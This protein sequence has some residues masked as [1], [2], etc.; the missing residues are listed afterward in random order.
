MNRPIQRTH[1]NHWTACLRELVALAMGIFLTC[2]CSQLP[3]DPDPSPTPTGAT[4]YIS[5]TGNDGLDGTT[6]ESAW[7]NWPH[8]LSQLEAGDTLIACDGTW[9]NDSEARA[10]DPQPV[11]V[12]A[13][14][15]YIHG[16]LVDPSEGLPSPSGM[17][18]KPITVRALNER[19]AFLRSNGSAAA[20]YA[21]DV[22]HWRFEGLRGESDDMD[23]S[24]TGMSVFHLAQCSRIELRR[25]L[26]AR[27]NRYKNTHIFALNHCTDCRVVEN[28]AYDFHR[29]G[30]SAQTCVGLEFTRNYA[31]SRGRADLPDDVGYN[32]H[33]NDFGDEG[34]TCYFSRGCLVQN[35][36]VE[37]S[38]GIQATGDANRVLGSITI[39]GHFG[40]RFAAN[41]QDSGS[42]LCSFSET[43]PDN[44]RYPT[45]NY[46]EHLL[47]IRPH[48]AGFDIDSSGSNTLRNFTAIDP[49]V[50]GF[51]GRD[52]K[53]TPG[54][55]TSFELQYGLTAMLEVDPA[56]TSNAGF[57]SHDGNPSGPWS[58][59]YLNAW[60][61]TNNYGPN[62]GSTPPFG[63]STGQWVQPLSVDP[64]LG[65]CRV[66]IPE[67]SPMW[68]EDGNCIGAQILYRYEGGVLTEQ[69]LWN[70]QSGAFPHGAL[71]DGVNGPHDGE[72]CCNVHRRLNVNC[73][74]CSLPEGFGDLA[75]D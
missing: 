2:G 26:G 14:M 69:P 11:L 33:T 65:P 46:G 30:F 21:G 28:E 27:N 34:L 17:P 16:T 54:F 22:E 15:P 66:F 73:N 63:S 71:I 32:S 62:E 31:H 64:Q 13:K 59:T 47:A 7:Q 6:Q 48:I 23:V 51:V 9:T 3:S 40:F 53:H 52:R 72:V 57:L 37:D 41:C 68:L 1:P 38:E 56:G 8:A 61:H 12:A 5:P 45:D 60:G 55:D 43:D 49:S 19:R 25:M 10:S 24:Y 18:G 75:K 39:G 44:D 50:W 58:G 35:C 29:H 67:G 70:P 74:G 36:I 20:L 4:Y 42:Q